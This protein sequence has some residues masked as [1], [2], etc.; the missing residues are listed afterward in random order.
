MKDNTYPT[1]DQLIY[2]KGIILDSY[3]YFSNLFFFKD[4]REGVEVLSTKSFEECHIQRQFYSISHDIFFQINPV[5]GKR[6]D[7][8]NKIVC[9]GDVNVLNIFNSNCRV[10]L[11]W[12]PRCILT[13]LVP[14]D[15]SI[16]YDEDILEFNFNEDEIEEYL[17]EQQIE[18]YKEEI[19]AAELKKALKC[20]FRR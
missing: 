19:K 3:S 10:I 4:I 5:K 17:R 1:K 2:N 20:V 15:D 9:D 14:I 11:G 6:L 13:L 12:R 7:K 18:K 8:N 16:G